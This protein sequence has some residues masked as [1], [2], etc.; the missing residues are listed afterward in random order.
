MGAYNWVSGDLSNSK[1]TLDITH[2]NLHSSLLSVIFWSAPFSETHKTTDSP[3]ELDLQ[4]CARTLTL[5]FIREP[6]EARASVD[7][8]KSE[9]TLGTGTTAHPF[10]AKQE[11]ID[12]SFHT[13][14]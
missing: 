4:W 8:T 12:I 9:R 13:Q 2:F 1:G 6:F 10:G 14:P 5:H 11:G 7:Q 3:S